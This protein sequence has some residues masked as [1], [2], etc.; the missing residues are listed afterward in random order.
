[1]F[2]LAWQE[3]NLWDQ[4]FYIYCSTIQIELPEDALDGC[5]LWS[6]CQAKLQQVFESRIDK[7]SHLVEFCF[8]I[9]FCSFPVDVVLVH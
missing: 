5:A 2:Q 4:L 1:M 6:L 9:L 3:Y 8:H 7:L